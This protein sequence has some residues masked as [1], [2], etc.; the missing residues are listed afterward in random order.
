M[1]PLP[2]PAARPLRPARKARRQFRWRPSCAALLLALSPAWALADWVKVSAS[3]QS[4]YY[5]D[6]DISKKVDG[7]VAVWVLRDHRQPQMAPHGAVL[8]SK[9]QL[10]VDCRGRRVRR[11]YASDHPQPMGRGAALRYEYGPMSWN[12]ALPGT[13]M[14]RV[15]DIACMRG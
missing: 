14:S 6:A 5:V 9:D 2:S 3:E 12:D 13:I 15:V 1:P 7:I 4:V 10:E 8:S 11:A